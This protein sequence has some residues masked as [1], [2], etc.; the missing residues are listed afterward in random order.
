MAEHVNHL[1]EN[2][3]DGVTVDI[4]TRSKTFEFFDFLFLAISA[5]DRGTDRLQ[6]RMQPSIG[7]AS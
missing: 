6:C 2:G 3:I 4:G 7:M 5:R 1:A